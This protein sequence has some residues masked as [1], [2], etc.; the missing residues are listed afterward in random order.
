MKKLEL[1]E[2]FS[3]GGSKYYFTKESGKLAVKKAGTVAVKK[4]FTP[5][6]LQ[7]VEEFFIFK[8]YDKDLAKRFVD[9]YSAGDWKD[10]RG[11][12]VKNWKQKAI[13]TWFKESNKPK[14]EIKQETGSKFGFL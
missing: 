5:P 13:S 10:Q 3:L 6:T 12:P 4:G 2:V 8:G 1:E 11:N 9:Y 14:Q 7:E